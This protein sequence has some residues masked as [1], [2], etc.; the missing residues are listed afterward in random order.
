MHTFLDEL[1]ALC[2]FHVEAHEICETISR[3][4]REAKSDLQLGLAEFLGR[5]YNEWNYR[6][7]TAENKEYWAESR[8]LT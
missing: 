2:R 5:A 8:R 6:D 4:Y 1:N 3:W 7:A